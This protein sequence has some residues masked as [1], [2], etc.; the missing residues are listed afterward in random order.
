MTI[1]INFNTSTEIHYTHGSMC[2]VTEGI[3]DYPT[4]PILVLTHSMA[5]RD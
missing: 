3:Q 5:C 1:F 4:Y 2:A